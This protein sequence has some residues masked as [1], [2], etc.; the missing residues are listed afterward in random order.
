MREINTDVAIIG[1]GTA[2]L[3]AHSAAIR[4]GAS[5]QLIEGGNYGTTCASVG[6][7][8]SKL[9][10]AAAD[11]AH[12]INKASEFGISAESHIDGKKLMDRV[13]SMRDQFTGGVVKMTENIPEDQRLIGYAEFEDSNTLVVGG[14]T[15]VHA[16]SIIIASGS[17][18]ARLSM[19]EDLGDRLVFNDDI[20]EWESLPKSVA[21]FGPGI[22]GL[23]LGQALHRLG[24]RIRMFG[25]QGLLG[26]LTDP[27]VK[28]NAEQIFGSE[29]PLDTDARVESVHRDGDDVIISFF[30]RSSDG[31]LE[32]SPREERFSYVLAATGRVPNLE[33]LNLD[34][35]GLELDSRGIPVYDPKTMQC[36]TS[37]IFIAGDVN[38]SKPLLHEASHEGKT[39]GKNAALF[40]DVQSVQRY[41]PLSIVFTDPQIAIVG[42][43]HSTLPDSA[44]AGSHDWSTDPRARMM[45]TDRGLLKVYG[46]KVDGRLLGAEI[47]GPHAENLAHLLSWCVEQKMT[48]DEMLD[49]P[50]YHPVYEEG[51]KKAL[52][53]LSRQITAED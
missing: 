25:V 42:N 9:L 2:G 7:M 46:D 52:Q 14:H 5:V 22:I 45:A 21:V 50:Y 6:C 3:T 37:S 40:P 41:T 13:R 24:V 16:G 26:P 10:I 15:R 19:F 32:K 31:N 27:E 12:G 48:V 35:S 20:F 44:T 29:F 36:G 28:S 49:K 30:A 51:L 34:K 4:N 23:E 33:N 47:L 43:S 39:A 11:A 38:S 53:D 1:A 18:P 17:R 8:P